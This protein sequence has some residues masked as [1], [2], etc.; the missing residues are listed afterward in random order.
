[1]EHQRKIV[2]LRKEL[3]ECIHCSE[4]VI[5]HANFMSDKVKQLEEQKQHREGLND[6]FTRLEKDMKG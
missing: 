5:K 3:K 4:C 6:I 2:Y 1:M